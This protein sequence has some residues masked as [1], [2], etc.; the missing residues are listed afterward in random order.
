MA[1]SSTQQRT[2]IFT[3]DVDDTP[4][5]MFEA[6]DIGEAR[7]IC[8][9]AWMQDGLVLTNSGG[10]PLWD[11][12]AELVARIATTVEVSVFTDVT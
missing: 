5:L 11:G 7:E 9:E 10:N 2:N 8:Q 1:C 4:I 6:K 12:D 3:L